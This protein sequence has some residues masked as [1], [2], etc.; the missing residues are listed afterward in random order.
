LNIEIETIF[1]ATIDIESEIA[2]VANQGDYDLLLVGLG[3]SIFEGTILGKVIGFTT[4]IINPDRLIDKFTGKEGLFENSPFD[5]RTRQIVA[6]TKMPLGILID[7]EFQDIDQVFIP[8][9][10]SDDSF[11][12]DY[13]Q[14]LIYN[15]NSKITILDV[16]GH[17][18]N[19]FVIQSAVT[20]LEQIHPNNLAIVTDKV[21]SL[22]FLE[23]QDLM[24]ISLESW[25]SLLDSDSDWLIG[26]PSVLI[27]KP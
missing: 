3:K 4:R 24:L 13:A 27:I 19:N 1:K 16:K 7:K 14:K 11:L 21:V 20:S 15:N 26:V 10:K 5:E 18:K 22:P 12:I 25:K 17:A 23:K 6:K 8:I 2:D 9:F